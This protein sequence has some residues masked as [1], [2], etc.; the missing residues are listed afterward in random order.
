MKYLITKLKVRSDPGGLNLRPLWVIFVIFLLIPSISVAQGGW[1]VNSSFQMTQGDF[2]AGNTTT[3]YYFNIGG[4]YRAETWYISTTLSLIVQDGLFSGSTTNN[5]MDG[6]G[7]SYRD[8]GI[9]DLNVFGE[10]NLLK[11]TNVLPWI[12]LS[13]QIKIPTASAENYFGTGEFDYGIGL[14]FRKK[15][16]SFIAF[17]DIGYLNLGDPELITYL[18]PLTFGIGIGRGFDYGRYSLSVYYQRYTKIYEAYPAPHQL[19]LGF[20]V[21]IIKRTFISFIGSKGL[22]ET[23]PNFSTSVG[24]EIYL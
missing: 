16:F 1:S 20:Y 6:S 2:V 9:G 17:G 14:T 15:L 19:S 23:S 10:I 13:S 11:G 4:R 12:S 24:L 5:M 7:T 18:N 8:I 22:S 3:N 21:N